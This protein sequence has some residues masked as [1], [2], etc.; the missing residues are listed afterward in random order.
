M[1]ADVVGADGRPPLYAD[2]I[3]EQL[4]NLVDKSLVVAD[5]FRLETRY[6]MLETIRQYALAKLVE[7]GEME[8]VRDRHLHYFAALAETAEPE[9]RRADQAAWYDRLDTEHDNLRAAVEWSLARAQPNLGLRLSGALYLFWDNRGYTREGRVRLA[10]M[11]AQPGAA[12]HT[13]ARTKALNSLGHLAWAQGDFD[14]ACKHL[15]EALVEGRDQQDDR[16]VAWSLQ[17]LGRIAEDQRHFDQARSL[18]E[19]SLAMRERL[20]DK[21]GMALSLAWLAD[22]ALQ[23]GEYPRAMALY[24]DNLLMLRQLQDKI[25]MGYVLRRMGQ[26]AMYLGDHPRAK[27]L[28]GEAINVHLEV[29]NKRGV[30][31]CIALLAAI[32]A[33]QGHM[34]TATRLYGT[35]TNLQSDGGVRHLHLDQVEFDGN[36]AK[37]RTQLDET[38]FTNAWASGHGLTLAQAIA[39]A[40]EGSFD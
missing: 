18:L 5:A 19:E 16:S 35:V 6:H 10:A 28:L 9:L 12:E 37:L 33:A 21:G 27:T 3:F 2:A 39:L 22:V 15:N 24:T 20:D 8:R 1:F 23:Q 7:S 38:S 17:L 26:V 13:S 34:R 30:I 14:S 40:L 32:Q 36:V 25:V 31:S 11:L 4:M 29:R